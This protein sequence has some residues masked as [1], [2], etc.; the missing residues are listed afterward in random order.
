MDKIG[1]TGLLFCAMLYA[2]ISST[3]ADI[4]LPDTDTLTLA[5][6]NAVPAALVTPKKSVQGNRRTATSSVTEASVEANGKH[7][8]DYLQL[9][10]TRTDTGL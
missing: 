9:H 7:F 3:R 4:R 2:N 8:S 6:A 5:N 10:K 1:V